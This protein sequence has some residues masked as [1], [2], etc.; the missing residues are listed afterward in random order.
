M[1]Y[2]IWHKSNKEYFAGFDMHGEAKWGKESEAQVWGNRLHAE[3]Q[4][5]LLVQ[6]DTDVQRKAI[7]LRR[8][9]A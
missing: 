9:I 1:T 3:I 5:L 2:A 4:A 8:N 7:F 6:D